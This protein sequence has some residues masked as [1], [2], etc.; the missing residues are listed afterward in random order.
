MILLIGDGA[1]KC[2]VS[3]L[4]SNPNEFIYF[5]KSSLTGTNK[6]IPD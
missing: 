3:F 1:K 6:K 4:Y 2:A 5:V